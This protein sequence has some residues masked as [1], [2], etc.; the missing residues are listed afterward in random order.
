MSITSS[1]A[2]G[3][4]DPLICRHRAVKK[5]GCKTF[6]EVRPHFLHDLMDVAPFTLGEPLERPCFSVVE[7]LLECL[8]M[9]ELSAIIEEPTY[10][11]LALLQAWQRQLTVCQQ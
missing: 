9:K 7:D 2:K 5:K 10:Y 8:D 3:Q 11:S 1:F 4:L 6:E